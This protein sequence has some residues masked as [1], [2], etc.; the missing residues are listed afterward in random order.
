MLGLT[1][2]V[3][4]LYNPFMDT[5]SNPTYGLKI[6]EHLKEKGK[7]HSDKVNWLIWNIRVSRPTADKLAKDE[8]LAINF[9]TLRRLSDALNV[10]VQDLLVPVN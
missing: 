4:F 10:P 1:I 2:C 3:G 7:K 6:S 8:G 9:T 5:N